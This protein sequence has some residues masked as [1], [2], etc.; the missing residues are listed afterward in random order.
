MPYKKGNIESESKP[1]TA[2]DFSVAKSYNMDLF[3][4]VVFGLMGITVLAFVCISIAVFVTISAAV[5][6]VQGILILLRGVIRRVVN[7]FR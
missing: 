5:F 1:D 7:V 4:K 2:K 3:S 6:L